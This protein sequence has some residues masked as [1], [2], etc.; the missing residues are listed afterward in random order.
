MFLNKK[1]FK[2]IPGPRIENF[3]V[4]IGSQRA[5]QV[6]CSFK[7]EDVGSL[8]LKLELDDDFNGHNNDIV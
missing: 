7:M 6:S 2:K 3:F 1:K 8:L 4:S 5:K